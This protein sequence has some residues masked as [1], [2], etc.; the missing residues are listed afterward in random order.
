MFSYF[1]IVLFIYALFKFE[2]NPNSN[3]VFWLI[4]L[5]LLWVNTHLYFGIGILIVLGFLI[6]QLIL[7][8]KKLKENKLIKKFS[9][10][11]IV[12]IPTIFIN[13]YGLGGAIHSL[14][15]NKDPNFPINSAE[16]GS[17]SSI[18]QSSPKIDNL[19][20]VIFEWM[21]VPL[22]ISFIVALIFRWKKKQPLF[23]RHYIFYLLGSVST[24][25]LSFD[26]IRSIPLFALIF[27]P[28]ICSNFQDIFVEC[29]IWLNK[30]SAELTKVISI[31]SLVLFVLI[32]IFYLTFTIR[33]II[34]PYNYFGVGL[35]PNSESSADFFINNN[36]TGPIF[37]DTDVGSYLIYYLY[38][39]EQVFTDNR[40]G[41]AY[42]AD[43]FANTYN[44]MIKDDTVWNQELAK[45]NFNVIFFN[46]YDGGDDIR[47]FLYRR[48]YD[49][50]WV[51]VY[52]DNYNVIF[53]RN[54]PA[55][56][57]VINK[58]GINNNNM[59]ERLSPLLNSS[60]PDT[61]LAAA[62]IYSMFGQVDL[63]VNEYL[64]FVSEMPA[65]GK[66]WMVLGRIELTRS[67]QQN[68]NPYLAATYLE[69][70]I[71]DGWV[72]PTSLSYLALAYYRTSQIDRAK[73]M[74]KK[75][76]Q[77][78]PSSTDGAEWLSVFAKQATQQNQ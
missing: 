25:I 9:W 35:A 6:E 18:L 69:H 71:A 23:S 53:V 44:P 21:L 42:S 66:V 15:V 48:Y 12:L 4:P 56:Q 41:D 10:L 46:Q 61:Q 13:P 37:N 65:R 47:N 59:T 17:I 5:E 73:A 77:I 39:K 7:N 34:S 72:T 29:K 11:L 76:L 45:Y 49:P 52:A 75:E 31:A 70:A 68:S 54:I 27:L 26:I 33:P 67:D 32:P 30:K 63:A 64:K 22:A 1:F 2:E 8:R 20:A 14:I 51:L 50:A 3:K 38:P 36:L 40:F 58:Y 57:A 28:A 74:V 60:D 62:D 55:N 19:I 16:L 43:F 24:A 78:D